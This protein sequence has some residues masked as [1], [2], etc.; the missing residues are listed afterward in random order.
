MYNRLID[1]CMNIEF[2]QTIQHPKK[3]VTSG[4]WEWTES[5]SRLL[6]EVVLDNDEIFPPCAKFQ[7]PQYF[8][9][10]RV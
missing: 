7:P 6:G 3:D 1:H 8:P 10:N 2:L 4:R 5:S 9:Q